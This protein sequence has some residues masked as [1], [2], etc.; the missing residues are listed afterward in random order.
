M[1]E[2][3]YQSIVYHVSPPVSNAALNALFAAAWAQHHQRDFGP[4]LAHSLAYVC[5]YIEDRLIGFV[6]LAWDG[7]IHA[8]ILDPTV[9]PQM[10]RRGIGRQ[11]VA[12]AVAIA[13][14]RGIQ[15]VHVDF[16]RQCGFQP[17]EAGLFA[18]TPNDS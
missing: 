4:V 15:W 11:L 8:F 2:P 13:R 5:A 3:P 14:R 6:N 17:T 16:E 10:Q 12:E 18:C 9:H 1:P 7:G